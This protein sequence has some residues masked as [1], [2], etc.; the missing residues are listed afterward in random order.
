MEIVDVCEVCNG[1]ETLCGL[2]I[3]ISS[4]KECT[5]EHEGE[6][7]PVWCIWCIPNK[8]ID[9]AMAEDDMWSAL[10][11]EMDRDMQSIVD[12]GKKPFT[13]MDRVE[14]YHAQQAMIRE[15]NSLG[16][17]LQAE[18]DAGRGFHADLITINTIINMRDQE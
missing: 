16:E 3:D 6:C 9:E 2:S 11:D 15:L 4:V 7:E 18:T 17:G 1:E 10:E 14:L 5:K 8:Q 12:E 13:K